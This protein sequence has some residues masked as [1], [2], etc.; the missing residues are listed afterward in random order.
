MADALGLP[1]REAAL[2]TDP[3]YNARL[4][5]AYLAKLREEFGPALTLVA[6]GYNAG[7]GRP[8]Q[9]IA[10]IGDPRRDDVDP[11]DWIEMVPFAETRSYIMRVAEALV[12]YRARAAGQAGPV[13]LTGLLAGR[14]R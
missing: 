9:W 12:I 6:A 13:D 8:R 5:A 7:P 10:Q 2:T 11:I 1:F 14:V 3:A 4:G